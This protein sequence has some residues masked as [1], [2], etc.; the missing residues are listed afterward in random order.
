[1][2]SSG[3][4]RIPVNFTPELVGLSSSR[5]GHLQSPTTD[6]GQESQTNTSRPGAEV[7]LT[8]LPLTITTGEAKGFN[9]DSRDA[10][11]SGNGR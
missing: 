7:L 8:W 3:W 4:R 6:Q 1:M 11:K 5:A 2:S 9:A 10:Y